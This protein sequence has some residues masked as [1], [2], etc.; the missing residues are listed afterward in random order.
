MNFSE[1]VLEH[2]NGGTQE[3]RQNAASDIKIYDK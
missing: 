1:D 3:S 2:S